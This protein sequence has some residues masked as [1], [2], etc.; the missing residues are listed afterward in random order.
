MK[1]NTKIKNVYAFKKG[2]L[3]TVFTAIFI[4][5]VIA[6]NVLLS[7]LA[8][9]VPLTLD[10]NADLRNT[11]TDENIEYIKSIDKEI[12]IYLYSVIGET[13]EKL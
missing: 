2:A 10:L 1:N 4:V 13:I 3:A 9:K 12:N 5:V 6:V 11:L 7:V 8:S